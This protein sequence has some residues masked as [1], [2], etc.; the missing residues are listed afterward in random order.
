MLAVR[1]RVVHAASCRL[2]HVRAERL[3]FLEVNFVFCVIC[4]Y[5]VIQHNACE[6]PNS[7]ETLDL[8]LR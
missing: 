1:Q 2:S 6:K 7:L 4:V 5:L 3:H 8:Y